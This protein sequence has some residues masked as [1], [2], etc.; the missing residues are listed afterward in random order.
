MEPTRSTD[1]AACHGRAGCQLLEGG[2]KPGRFSRFYPRSFFGDAGWFL[3]KVPCLLNHSAPV[4]VMEKPLL[5]A[6]PCLPQPIGRY[7]S[8]II[9]LLRTSQSGHVQIARPPGSAY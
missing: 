5:S 9:C 1:N 2:S 4:S 7:L 6:W 3:V 8:T